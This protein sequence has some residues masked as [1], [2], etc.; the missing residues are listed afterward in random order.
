MTIPELI[1]K[2]E[3]ATRPDRDLDVQISNLLTPLEYPVPIPPISPGGKKH[4]AEAVYSAWGGLAIQQQGNSYAFIEAPHYTAS[5]DAAAQLCERVLPG[6]WW[7]VGTCCVSDDACVAP[8]FNSPIHGERL[9]REYHED[10]DYTEITDVDQR[11]PGRP[12]IALCI[13]I[14]RAAAQGRRVR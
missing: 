5:I 7:K 9:K 2:L 10:V 3:K 13:A 1:E 12:A 4:Y 8:D 14:L 6:W 11:P